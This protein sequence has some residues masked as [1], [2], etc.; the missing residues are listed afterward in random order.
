MDDF[1]EYVL[2]RYPEVAKEYRRYSFR[3]KLPSIGDKVRTLR[4]G[5][6]GSAGQILVVKNIYDD[7]IHL[8]DN[9]YEYLSKIENWYLDIEVI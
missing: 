3:E 9:Q 5:F 8:S 6:G 2:K 1:A 4:S 7:Y